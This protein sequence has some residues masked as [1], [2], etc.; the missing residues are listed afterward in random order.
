MSLAALRKAAA[1]VATEEDF[2]RQPGDAFVPTEAVFEADTFGAPALVEEPEATVAPADP[3]AAE[4][5]DEPAS[6]AP[7]AAGEASAEWITPPEIV[8]ALGSDAALSEDAAGSSEGLVAS[9]V[10]EDVDQ[11]VG[12]AHRQEETRPVDVVTLGDPSAV[13]EAIHAK[14]EGLVD[15]PPLTADEPVVDASAG[16]VASSIDQELAGI[17]VARDIV[18][19]AVAP[20]TKTEEEVEAAAKA[21]QAT[22][23]ADPIVPG[24]AE[25]AAAAHAEGVPGV[26][27]PEAAELAP[28]EKA[29]DEFVFGQK[30]AVELGIPADLA[31]MIATLPAEQAR[32]FVEGLRAERSAAA[33]AKEDKDRPRRQ[34]PMSGGGGGFSLF[35]GLAAALGAVA[36]T[37]KVKSDPATQLSPENIRARIEEMR[38][39]EI[40][41][42][43]AR[44]SSSHVAMTEATAAFNQ[45][46]L[47]TES[48]K[49]FET[50]VGELAAAHPTLDRQKI[51]EMSMSGALSAAIGSDPLK[52]LVDEAFKAAEVRNAW[53]RMELH[54]DAVEKDGKQMLERMKAFEAQFP[55]S[56]DTEELNKVVDNAM[57]G[58]EKGFDEAIAQSPEAKRA[59]KDRLEELA[60][61]VREFIERLL[62]KLGFSPR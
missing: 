19:E 31:K 13:T 60:K 36:R 22:L 43:A 38:R 9:T 8:V 52:P 59:W 54:A 39:T 2:D 24:Q 40:L 46:L 49:A 61:Q 10:A 33:A 56:V 28:A 51:M 16:Q 47:S 50:K 21:A 58:I 34:A 6:V 30:E 4:T 55:K 7:E 41:D 12:R 23:G 57:N 37:A 1:A 62:S 53:E 26:V 15:A 11:Q 3:V 29:E 32:R 44:V 18:A 17:A 20:K 27:S 48:G 25:A 5:A 42:Q 35:G 45:A 14:R